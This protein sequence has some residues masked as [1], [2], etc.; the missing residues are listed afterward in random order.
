[1]AL[2]PRL[3]SELLPIGALGV[4]HPLGVGCRS[5]IPGTRGGCC[6]GGDGGLFTHHSTNKSPLMALPTSLTT[7][8]S[9]K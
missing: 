3:Y 2:P 9:I 5:L 4:P 8:Q 7:L 6:R 1:M